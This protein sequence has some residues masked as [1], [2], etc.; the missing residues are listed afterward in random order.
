VLG[1]RYGMSRTTRDPLE[2]YWEKV[3]R[4][5]P[6]DCWEWTA[7]R[8]DNGYGAFR[9]GDKQ[10]KAHRFGYEAL[11]GP[12]P[13]GQYVL[14]RCD[15]PPC[16]NPAHWFL[17]THKDNAEDRQAKGRGATGERN[18]GRV[19]ARFTAVQV[20]E[21]R[22]AAQG[23]EIHD[24]IAARYDTDQGTV[25]SIVRRDCWAHTDLDIPA[26]RGR[27]GIKV[28]KEMIE[29]VCRE[30]VPGQ[31]RREDLAQRFGVS[32]RTISMILEGWRP[33]HLE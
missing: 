4:R 33:N 5:G 27:S 24:S 13:E 16:C 11:V 7:A 20:R 29:T 21:I 23:G 8:F 25:S 3:D 14:H 1:Y 22:L 9:L 2:R 19:V 12:I 10:K 32:R 15:N 18:G 17:G 31:V 26:R 28:T 30:Y 6:G